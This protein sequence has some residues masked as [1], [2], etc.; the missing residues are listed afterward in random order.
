MS[1]KGAAPRRRRAEGG[2]D[3]DP[4]AA[5]EDRR[6]A[7]RRSPPSGR[8]ARSRSPTS[9]RGPASRSPHCGRSSPGRRGRSCATFTA[10]IDAEVLAGIDREMADEP[11]R[12]RILDTVM[13]RFDQASRPYKA[14]IRGLARAARC[15]PGLGA[16][17]R[18]RRPRVAAVDARLG[19]HRGGE[20][21]SAGCAPPGSASSTPASCR[22]GSTTRIPASP[23]PSPRSTRRSR[24]ARRRSP[25]RKT[26]PAASRASPTACAERRR[27]AA[28]AFRPGRRRR[29]G[30]V[31]KSSPC[32]R[33]RTA[34]AKRRQVGSQSIRFSSL[35]DGPHSAGCAGCPSPWQGGTGV[36]PRRRR[37]AGRTPRRAAKLPASIDLSCRGPMSA[38]SSSRFLRRAR[39]HHRLRRLPEG[40]RAR[41]RHR[42]GGALSGGAQAGDQAQDRLRRADRRQALLGA[43]HRALPA[44][45]A[46]RPPRA[47]GGQLPAAADQENSCPRC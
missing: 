33:G 43:D 23:A 45:R 35:I 14:G 38:P 12:D 40:R 8:G 4:E 15:E 34:F 27:P 1:L 39:R 37:R 47:G 21:R 16:G 24:A 30:V 28:P 18:P 42:R 3:G 36:P 10:R 26:S 17:A 2:C 19:W 25:A 41:R 6:C 44:G 5:S 31:E 20:P 9:P 32:Q 22:C 46:R 13:R 7:P 29:R 11:A